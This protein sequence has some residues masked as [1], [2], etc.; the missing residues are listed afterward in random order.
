MFK[1]LIPQSQ[2]ELDVT[3]MWGNQEAPETPMKAAKRMVL[4]EDQA[5]DS[6]KLLLI[7]GYISKQ[8][9]YQSPSYS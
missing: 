8:T 9:G 3:P 5:E 7:Y 2:Q 6:G 1:T 4:G